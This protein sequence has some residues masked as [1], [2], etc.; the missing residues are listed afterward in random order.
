MEAQEDTNEGC[1]LRYSIKIGFKIRRLGF[2]YVSTPHH[3][4]CWTSSG[5][6]PVSGRPSAGIIRNLT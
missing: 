5:N 3:G 6:K 2:S 4:C 1:S